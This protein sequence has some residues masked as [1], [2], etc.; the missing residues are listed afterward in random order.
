[1]IGER[2]RRIIKESE[3]LRLDAYICPAGRLTIGY[4]HTMSAYHGQ[5]ITE[6]E[7][8]AL[9]EQDLAVAETSINN[10]VVVP[11]TEAMR[12]ALASWV[13][14]LGGPKLRISTLLRKLNLRQYEGVPEEIKR[15]TWGRVGGKMEQ[16][17][18]LIA[19]RE[20]EAELFMED[21]LPS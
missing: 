9:L 18:G 8:D 1:M 20:K 10:L 12:D 21:G 13:F 14:N 15:W 11:M 5:R 19:R 7:A 4:G 6:A 2:G 17:P 3:G 16:L